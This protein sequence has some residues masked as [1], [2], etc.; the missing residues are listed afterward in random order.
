MGYII[1]YL[2]CAFQFSPEMETRIPTSDIP[3]DT[4]RVNV[5]ETYLRKGEYMLCIVTVVSDRVGTSL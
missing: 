1:R 2:I 5:C 4:Y 3:P